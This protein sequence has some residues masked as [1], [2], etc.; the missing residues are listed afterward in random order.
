MQI[1][2]SNIKLKL[3]MLHS[4]FMKRLNSTFSFSSF[5]NFPPPNG[6]IS[7]SVYKCTVVLSIRTKK[8]PIVFTAHIPSLFF[9][10]VKYLI[11]LVYTCCLKFLTFYFLLSPLNQ[12]S[13]LTTKPGQRSNLN[14]IFNSHLTSHQ[15]LLYIFLFSVC[16][17]FIPW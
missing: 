7:T 4:S 16:I 3:H 14:V 12:V 10:T 2:Q 8:T 15:Y 11:R 17:Q 1:P 6:Y 9:I 13:L 5:I